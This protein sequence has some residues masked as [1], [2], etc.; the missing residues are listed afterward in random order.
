MVTLGSNST[1]HRETPAKLHEASFYELAFKYANIWNLELCPEFNIC[2]VPVIPDTH[3]CFGDTGS[4]LYQI[5]CNN[6]PC[7]MGVAS[8]SCND[9]M[10]A[11]TETDTQFCN[12]GIFFSSIPYFY[13]WI[14]QIIFSERW[15]NAV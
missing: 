6:K 9:S 5:L 10:E 13:E 3:L 14:E 12:N 4:P 8:Y 11:S 1:E 7:L 15:Q 2:T